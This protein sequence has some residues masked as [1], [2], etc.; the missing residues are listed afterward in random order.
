MARQSRLTI[1]GEA[2]LLLQT[3]HNRQPVFLDADDQAHYLADLR[4]VSRSHGVA[5]HA[6]ALLPDRV[7][8]LATP[9]EAGSLSRAMQAL[10]R[11]H[12]PWHN[13]RHQRSGT[14]WEGRFRTCVVESPARLLAAMCHVE[15]LSLEPGM[16]PELLAQACSSAAHHLGRRRDPLVTDPAPYWAL[17]NT[18]FDREAQYQQLL[19]Q[20]P[21]ADD[22]RQI[23]A[24]LR[25]GGVWG[26]DT[27]VA[28]L[29]AQTARPLVAR[30]RGRPR[31]SAAA[32]AE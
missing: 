7:C 11:R 1:A 24:A 10:G 22:T 13:Q 4:E 2:H 28:R 15:R 27:F 5:V 3:G 21:P 19:A 23:D 9:A 8:L 14:L 18:P 6:Y 29:Q 31:K 25:K 12:V 32:A 20:E 26:S 16:A 30:P 17:G